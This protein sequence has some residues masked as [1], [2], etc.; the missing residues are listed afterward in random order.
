VIPRLGIADVLGALDRSTV[1]V[2]LVDRDLRFLHVNP[3][4]AAMN[5]L[6]V[7]DHLGRTLA[8]ILPQSAGMLEP[9][10]ER[11]L[12]GEEILDMAIVAEEVAGGERAFTAS[13]LPVGPPGHPAG[14]LMLVV[15]RDDD[16]ARGVLRVARERLEV[17]LEGTE[18]GSFEWRV[19]EDRIR[20][21]E[22]LGPLWGRER[23]WAPDG[24]EA[25]LATVADEDR[26]AV[27]EAV[28]RTLD[29]G[30]DGYDLEFR[31]TRPDGPV[32]WIHAR[33]HVLRDDDGRP[34]VLVGL[35]SDA[36]ARMQREHAAAFLARASL[37]LSQSLDAEATL[38]RVADLAVPALA[39]WCVVHLVGGSGRP[40]EL[41]V[42]HGEPH[43]RRLV[44]EL[45]ASYPPDADAPAGVTAVVRSGR[46]EL[47]P[48][49]TEEVL[50]AASLDERHRELLRQL[51]LRSVMVVPIA[52][53]GRPLGAITFAYAD[54]GREYTTVELELAEELGR[55]AGLALDNARLHEAERRSRQRLE[56]LQAVTD[57]GLTHLGLDELMPELLG[58]VREISGGDFAVLLL[59]DD[60]R[61]QLHVRAAVGLEEEVTAEVRIPLGRGIAGR[62]AARGKPELIEDLRGREVISPYLRERA[63]SM[64]AV[65]LRDNEVIGVLHV[66]SRERARFTPADV[67]L[68]ELV[69]D[70]VGRAI[71][72]ARIYEQQRDIALTLQRSLLP[73]ALSVP[74]GY[75]AA[76]RY[77][78]GTAGVEV[79]GDWYDLFR[80]ADGRRAIVV[81]DV[82]GRGTTAAATMGTLRA[83]LR[84]DLHDTEDPALALGKVDAL[85]ADTTPGAFA[86]ALALVLDPEAGTVVAALAGHPPPL[87]RGRRGCRQPALPI[88]PPL[89]VAAPRENGSFRLDRGE[90]LLLY[91]DGLVERPGT[92]L[93]ERLRALQDAFADTGG[94]VVEEVADE[95]LATM[96]SA[97]QRPDDVALLLLRRDS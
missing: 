96:L 55:R 66:S 56:Q 78:P 97:A 91:T 27:R 50:E 94:G 36:T 38:R 32:R 64:A 12:D 7:A 59:L 51:G 74:E 47:H 87:V 83:A 57:V 48:S 13:Y 72:Q 19:G 71:T 15:A 33:T 63:R 75:E 84:A 26:E 24:Y 52:A 60:R 76:A 95:L 17:A 70:R 40:E 8:E 45:Q 68:L 11:V 2:A 3:A 39:D 86:T 22:N 46:S 4:L 16:P 77:L 58:R 37:A 80:L 88:R 18:T 29:D 79:G 61:E 14:V 21:S 43:K 5:R 69:A 44:A 42:A 92:P 1:G 41:A 53:R 81:G 65:P 35:V 82:A 90:A 25:F 31:I 20:W 93:D 6:S 10:L 89:G 34:A 9:L 67:Q 85:L 54:S 49:I 28:G 73:D 30:E 23:G 62:I